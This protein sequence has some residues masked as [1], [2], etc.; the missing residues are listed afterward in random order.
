[1]KGRK[2]MTR[3]IHPVAGALAILT[4]ATFWLSTALSELFASQATVTAVKTAIPWGFLLLVPAL[5]ATGGSGLALA[6]GR[7]SGSI[8]TKI[9]RMR[10]IA[11]NGMLVLI[12]AALFLASKSRAGGFDTSFY[13]VQVIEL[14]A[15]AA[16]ITLLGLNMRD[17][18][19]L[20]GWFRSRPTRSP[21]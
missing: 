4:I 19:N 2:A 9:K 15:G 18:L 14:V 17:G 12:P 5:A 13:V 21:T 8:G 7:R 3:I 10:I 16:N 6:K 11:P 1:M 20:K